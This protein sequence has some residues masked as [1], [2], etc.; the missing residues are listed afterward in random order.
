VLKFDDIEF[1][2]KLND[3]PKIEKMKDLKINVFGLCKAKEDYNIEPPYINKDDIYIEPIN[4]L[5]INND[6]CFGLFWT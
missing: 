3:I 4:L 2:I 6:E 1:P 5:L